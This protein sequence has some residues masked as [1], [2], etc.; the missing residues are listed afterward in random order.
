M[1]RIQLLVMVL[2]LTA[3]YFLFIHLP[4]QEEPRKPDPIA[5]LAPGVRMQESAP[6]SS[7][8]GAP[9]VKNKMDWMDLTVSH[10]LSPEAIEAWSQREDVSLDKQVKGHPRSGQ[11]LELSWGKDPITTAVF[12]LI[13]EQK[14]QLS[15]VRS[16]YPRG[17]NFS[18]LKIMLQEKIKRPVEREDENS[19]VFTADERGLTVW[20]ARSED[21]SVKVAYEYGAHTHASAETLP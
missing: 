16:L 14:Y 20:L 5:E 19:V 1:R 10:Q 15:A 18:D 11:R 4:K 12:D 2:I 17:T 8:A 6:V 3:C 13:G 21:G 9:E 7:S